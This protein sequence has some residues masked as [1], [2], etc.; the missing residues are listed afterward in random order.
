VVEDE[1]PLR[2]LVADILRDEGYQVEE[3]RDGAQALD[4]LAH[5]Q[6][7][8]LCAVVLD[9]MLPRLDGVGVLRQIQTQAPRVPVVAMSASREHLAAAVTAGAQGTV[10][11]PFDIDHLVDVVRRS[12][13]RPMA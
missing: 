3:A 5:Q 9:M 8:V 4:A 1:A 13:A 10:P 6:E 7:G 2:A 11:K 12:C